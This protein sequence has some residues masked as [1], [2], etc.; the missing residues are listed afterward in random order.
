MSSKRASMWAR[1]SSMRAFSPRSISPSRP[2]RSPNRLLLIRIPIST[3]S[4][5]GTEASAIV[6][7]WLSFIS[8]LKVAEREDFSLGRLG[9]KQLPHSG[10]R[11]ETPAL[12]LPSNHRSRLTSGG[13]CYAAKSGTR[14]IVL[15]RLVPGAGFRA[16]EEGQVL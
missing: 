10:L 4:I 12:L 16:E 5:V 9:G 2:F 7:I 11:T 13:P 8:I 6:R 1:K 14:G 3:A 15:G